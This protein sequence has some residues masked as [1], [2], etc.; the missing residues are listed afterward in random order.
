MSQY[1]HDEFVKEYLPEFLADY[2]EVIPSA[3]VS[4]ERREIDVLF[5]PTKPVPTTPET[6]GLLG[7]LA[8]TICLFE[9]YRNAI[10]PRQIRQCLGKLVNVQENQWK[11]ATKESKNLDESQLAK[12]W[13]ITPTISEAILSKFKAD[14][15]PNWESGIYFLGEGL[16]TG[17]VTVHQL[18]VNQDTLWLRI[19]GKGKVSTWTKL[20]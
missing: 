8:Q 10:Q 9:V 15:S 14:S 11:Q 4:S 7:K 16:F 12:L 20:I 19:L 5:T 2:G 13:I 1:P 3:D 18:P 17:I 6:L